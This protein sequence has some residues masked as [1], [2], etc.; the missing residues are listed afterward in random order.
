MIKYQFLINY[1]TQLVV[2]PRN[3]EIL[4]PEALSHA[5]NI[6]SII[7]IKTIMFSLLNYIIYFLSVYYN[8]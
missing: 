3:Q 4:R 7:T 6:S 8:P 5:G 1:N 2:L